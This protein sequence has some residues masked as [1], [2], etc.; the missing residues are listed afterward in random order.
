[1]KKSIMELMKK[2]KKNCGEIFLTM[3]SLLWML[4]FFIIPILIILTFAFKTA[5]L[6][7]GIGDS[8][9]LDNFKRMCDANFFPVLWRTVWLSA[10][11]TFLCLVI[12]LPTGYFLGRVKRKWRDF[13]LMLIIVP[14]WTNF[15]IR[16]FAWKT[17]LHP[18]GL[19]KKIFV[20]L[21]IVSDDTL[22][23]Y[24]PGAVL[25]VLIY[26]HLPFAI[27]PI[28]AAAEKFDYSLLEA[29]Y[30]LGA[31]KLQALF[32]VFIPAIS[33]GIIA[34]V[35]VVFIPALGSYIIP[36][37]VGGA[38][39]EMLGNKIARYTSVDRNLPYASALSALL[40]LFILLPVL[41][42][43]FNKNKMSFYKK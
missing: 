38:D 31:G 24:N 42:A 33:G 37:L 1:M 30:D 39:S 17:I 41:F 9:N 40:A 2:L 20:A 12:A 18:D 25:L 4:F 7:G 15:L 34:A 21:H 28:Y 10:T 6:Y 36:D 29:A 14:F 27:L 3:P 16:I 22:L 19:L 32:R 43:L 35:L 8:W 5:D 26:T 23:L 11:A 13:L